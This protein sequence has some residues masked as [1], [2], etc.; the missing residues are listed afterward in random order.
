MIFL[1][2]LT[3][4]LCALQGALPATAPAA[5]RIKVNGSLELRETYDSNVFLER[6]GTLDDFITTIVPALNL[7]YRGNRI[8]IDTETSATFFLYGEN[9]ELNDQF[10]NQREADGL[11]GDQ[12]DFP[13]L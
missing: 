8:N 13:G 9:T 7:A 6:H 10:F 5:G 12:I 4:L 1:I 11:S 3:S 2:A